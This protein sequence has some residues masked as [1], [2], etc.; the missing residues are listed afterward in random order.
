[1]LSFLPGA[2]YIL[3]GAEKQSIYLKAH[4]TE[5]LFDYLIYCLFFYYT[6]LLYLT[7]VIN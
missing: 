4:S 2:N 7:M 5:L 6:K 3:S 1:M